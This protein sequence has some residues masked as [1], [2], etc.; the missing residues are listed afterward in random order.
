SA[1]HAAVAAGVYPH[2]H[3]AAEAMG[4][5]KA[6]VVTPIPENKAVYDELYAEYKKLY[7][8]FGR[9]D[10]PVMKRLKH[11]RNLARKGN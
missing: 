9:G 10:N 1:I 7:N 3:S 5:L 4:K 11:I 8:T 2:I 6:E